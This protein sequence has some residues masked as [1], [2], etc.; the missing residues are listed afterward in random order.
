[1]LCRLDIGHVLPLWIGDHDV[2]LPDIEVESGHVWQYLPA[3]KSCLFSE[4]LFVRISTV[5]LLMVRNPS[6]ARATR[7]S[8]S[9]SGAGKGGG[10]VGL[11]LF[12]I[13]KLTRAWGEDSRLNLV[14]NAPQT[15]MHI[16]REQR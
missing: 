14:D 12:E 7:G 16:A 9:P 13:R 4:N 11:T 8:T 15:L 1:V 6:P 2:V 3:C 10:A 5:N